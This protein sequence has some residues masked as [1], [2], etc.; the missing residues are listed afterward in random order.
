MP[1]GPETLVTI[2]LMIAYCSGVATIGLPDRGASSQYSANI[3][4]LI[5]GWKPLSLTF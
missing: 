1:A 4:W 5:S 2:Y 3:I